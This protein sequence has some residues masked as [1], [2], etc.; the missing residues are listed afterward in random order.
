MAAFSPIA[1]APAAD[2]FMFDF[3]IQI[4]VTGVIVAAAWI[5]SVDPSSP[6]DDPNATT[7]I[8]GPPSFSNTKTS[9][10]LG[11]MIDGCLYVLQA[12]V[13]LDDNR[14]LTDI[15]SL[16]CTSA[17]RVTGVLTPSDFR[18]DFP[19]F[20]DPTV[21]TEDALAFWIDVVLY[22]T[23]LNPRSWR[24]SLVLGQEL[25]VAH[26]LT[27]E[28]QNERQSQA[29]QAPLAL[30]PATSRSVGGVSVGYDSGS[31]AYTTD[32]GFWNMST[33]GQRFY[34]FQNIA[35]IRPIQL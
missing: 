9:A 4:G 25:Y 12:E 32:A 10:L 30:G 11:N 5:C 17:P 21:Y 35:G 27:L 20:S 22:Q 7:R 28:R 2:T 19:A 18:K 14:V 24:N 16:Q 8:L 15:A 26:M 1:P 33:Y 29:G 13:T 6:V 23:P 3:T 31:G 34:Y